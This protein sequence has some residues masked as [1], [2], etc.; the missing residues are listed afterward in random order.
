MLVAGAYFYSKT[1][2]AYD[3]PASFFD[4]TELPRY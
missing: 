4:I 2:L 3:E 1:K